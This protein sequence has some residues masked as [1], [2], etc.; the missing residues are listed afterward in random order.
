MGEGRARRGTVVLALAVASASMLGAA[1]GPGAAAAPA[2]APSAVVVASS[3]SDGESGPASVASL[4]EGS[5][6]DLAAAAEARASLSR[7]VARAASVRP[8]RAAATGAQVDIFYVPHQD[9]D[10][11]SM[12]PLIY[13]R[14]TAG[15]QVI[16]VNYTDGRTTGVCS[17]QP[18]GLCGGPTEY[19]GVPISTFVR[20]RTAELVHS[21]GS[22]GVPA[23]Q[24][25][26]DP[27]I[28]ATGTTPDV[29]RAV[30][31][32]MTLDLASQVVAYYA[33][34]YPG[35]H[36]YAM[37][38]IDNHPDHRLMGLA[39]RAATQLGVVAPDRARFTMFRIYWQTNYPAPL[40][41]WI[42]ARRDTLRIAGGMPLDATLVTCQDTGCRAAVDAAI[43][44][45]HVPYDIGYRSVPAYLDVVL[46]DP[47][48]AVL[49]H[50]PGTLTYTGVTAVTQTS[51]ALGTTTVS[52]TC[53]PQ[54]VGVIPAV[55]GDATMLATA[56][57]GA[58]FQAA[59]ASGPRVTVTVLDAS[60]RAA[61]TQSVVAAPGGAWSADT[62]LSTT[63]ASVQVTCAGSTYLVPSPT[64]VPVASTAV[65]TWVGTSAAPVLPRLPG[66]LGARFTVQVAVRAGS[67][68][69]PGLTLVLS[70]GIFG[71][72]S[73]SAVTDSDGIATLTGV[74][75][76]A[77]SWVLRPSGAL[78]GA[79]PPAS[80]PVVMRAVPARAV[81]SF[82][83]SAYSRVASRVYVVG[84]LW[85]A[86]G[87][88]AR[89]L[90]GHRIALTFT[91]H[92]RPP[93]LVATVSVGGTG[94]FGARL[95]LGGAGVLRA[96]LLGGD[97][98]LPGRPAITSTTIR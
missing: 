13:Q 25:V 81:A 32:T 51:A 54:S 48:K 42:P 28:P 31:G 62:V 38:W 20:D 73:S 65:V 2:S 52:G 91:R 45:Y 86:T 26:T 59:A 74:I 14:V 68:P 27:L 66:T 44:S 7:A 77:S 12:G 56:L 15:D 80:V 58:R 53:S 93:Q 22:L 82:T 36:H 30:D 61:S 29:P 60:G 40:E 18:D 88:P 63:A 39:L 11:L 6:T 41:A 37:S 23:D 34:R 83:R 24:V 69:L 89:Y 9:D 92:G 10:A 97:P 67:A 5:R 8:L 49:V 46:D 21:V 94:W 50:G 96:D 78:A 17:P 76:R 33:A 84:R 87:M 4:A 19:A 43:A 3:G 16:V 55:L 85:T 90:A 47:T 98:L 71:D 79:V 57:D 64:T 35:A 72:P 70:S 75:G 1:L 95:R